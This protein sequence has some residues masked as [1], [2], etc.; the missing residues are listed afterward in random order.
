MKSCHKQTELEFEGKL[1]FEFKSKSGVNCEIHD[2]IFHV[3]FY[4]LAKFHSVF[5]DVT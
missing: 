5:R 1:V 4:K 3:Q 2:M